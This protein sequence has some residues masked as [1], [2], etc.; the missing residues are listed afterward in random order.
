MLKKCLTLKGNLPIYEDYIIRL[1]AKLYGSCYL[2]LSIALLGIALCVSSRIRFS[3]PHH[4]KMKVVIYAR[5]SSDS[6][7]E[8]S[9]EGQLRE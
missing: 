8:E 2:V 3:T 9:I 4:N 6:Q 7:R 1:S 5:Y